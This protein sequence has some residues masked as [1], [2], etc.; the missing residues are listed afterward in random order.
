[1]LT[2]AH[3]RSRMLTYGS[4]KLNMNAAVSNAAFSCLA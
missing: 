1:M 3:V 2:Y 4:E